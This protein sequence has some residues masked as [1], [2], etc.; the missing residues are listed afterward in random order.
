[1]VEAAKQAI[2]DS[3]QATVDEIREKL[4]NGASFDDLIKEYGTDTGL[5]DDATRAQGYLAPF[6]ELQVPEEV[7]KAAA[8][9]FGPDGRHAYDYT[10]FYNNIKENAV[11]RVEAYKAS[12]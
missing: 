8:E 1:M 3:V 2:L 7:A 10:Y 9:F 12:H 11:K 4:N 5:Q 6:P